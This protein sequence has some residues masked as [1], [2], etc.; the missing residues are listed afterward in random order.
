MIKNFTAYL[1]HLCRK[2]EKLRHSDEER[3]FVNLNEDSQNT[4]LAEELHYP[5]V[6]FETTGY[7]ISGGSIDEMKKTYTCHIEV[8]THVS[9]TG[10]YVEVES[11]LSE[12]ERIID[13]IFA[14]INLDKYRRTPKW[15]QGMSFDGI[16]VV[17]L[18][19]EKNALY[20]WMAE[21]MLQTPYCITDNN[22]FK[23]E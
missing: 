2:H 17:P 11:A 7:R 6:F 1:E 21:V 12:T 14:K 10:D 23:T 9:D 19:N 4:S 20:G 22:V 15:L 13:D 3:H 5:A 8:F 16:D 18:Q